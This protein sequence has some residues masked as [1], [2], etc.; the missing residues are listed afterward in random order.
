MKNR[1]ELAQYFAELGFKKGVEVGLCTGPYSKVLLDTIPG[2]QLIGIDPYRAYQSAYAR[3]GEE[4]QTR[5]LLQAREL[6]APY[7]GFTLVINTGHEVSS[8]LA[9]GSID[10]VFIDGAHDYESVKQDISDWVPKIRKGGIVSGHDYYE[11]K[12]GKL[13]V[14]RAVDEYVQEHDLV[15][16]TTE[17]D[18]ENPNR[19]ER[20]PSWHFTI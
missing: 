10:F 20:Q 18:E 17:W 11:S 4:T 7:P 19:D 13:G 8:W 3:R 9:D 6:L 14:K 5:N 2:L 16:G 1:A 15:L 12:S